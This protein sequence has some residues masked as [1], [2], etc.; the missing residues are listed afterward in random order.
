MN[1]QSSI[2]NRKSNGRFRTNADIRAGR[3]A[4]IERRR[5]LAPEYRALRAIVAM[6]RQQQGVDGGRTFIVALRPGDVGGTFKI[7]E[8]GQSSIINNP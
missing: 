4:T 3:A 8:A 1:R 2:A 7:P 6:A 5:R